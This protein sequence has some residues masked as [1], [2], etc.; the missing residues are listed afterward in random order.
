MLENVTEQASDR[1]FKILI[2]KTKYMVFGHK[3]KLPWQRRPIYRK[4]PE[5]V[6]HLK[7]SEMWLDESK[8][9]KIHTEKL[10]VKCEKI[11]NA[12]R[13]GRV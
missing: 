5:K 3:K 13:C 6:K 8:T 12:L 4:D 1:R 10:C 9:W 11:L 7:C 2:D